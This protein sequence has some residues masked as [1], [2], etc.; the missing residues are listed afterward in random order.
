MLVPITMTDRAE[1]STG[2]C[3]RPL[4][5]YTFDAEGGKPFIRVVPHVV[6]CKHGTQDVCLVNKVRK[7]HN[8][9]KTMVS[10]YVASETQQRMFC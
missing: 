8:M 10:V 4:L 3:A 1:A 2:K 9:C 7:Y 6:S 5:L